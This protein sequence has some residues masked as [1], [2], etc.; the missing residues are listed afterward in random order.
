MYSNVLHIDIKSLP[1]N[2]SFPRVKGNGSRNV[3]LFC[4]IECPHCIRTERLFNEIGDMTIHTFVL[5]VAS[6]HPDAPRKTNAV[7]CSEDKANAWQSWFDKGVLPD[8]KNNCKAPLEEIEKFA[9]KNHIE[10]PIIIFED[11]TGYHAED[12]IFATLNLKQLKQLFHDHSIK[13]QKKVL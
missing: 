12:F 11:G 2:L 6:Y 7:W 3:Y 8:N 1:M 13:S 10:L 5:P 4:D 9:H